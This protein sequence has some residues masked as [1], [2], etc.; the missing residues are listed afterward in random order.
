MKALATVRTAGWGGVALCVAVL[1]VFAGIR[2]A[3]M[4]GD[5]P[6]VGK[7]EVRYV[8]HPWVAIAHI[9]PGLLFVTLA[10]LQF[11]ARIRQRHIRLHRALGRMLIGC[12]ALSGVFALAAAFRFPAFGGVSTQSATVF[13][14]VILLFS[15]G[16]ALHHIRRREVSRHREWMIRAFAL[17]LGVAGI[18]IIIGLFQ[19]LTDLGFEQVFGTAFWMAFS[20]NLVIAEVWINVTRA[21]ST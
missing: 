9:V 1:L 14:G 19:A 18:R 12:A 5:A 7:F 16:K 13:F 10:P 20:I 4:A 11:V 17:A 6:P 21:R 8:E 3:D 2:F 15:L